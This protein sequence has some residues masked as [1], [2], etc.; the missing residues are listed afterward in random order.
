MPTIFNLGQISEDVYSKKS[1]FKSSHGIKRV[2]GT[3]EGQK[4]G[5]GAALYRCGNV[6]VICYSGSDDLGDVAQD[7]MLFTHYKVQFKQAVDFANRIVRHHGL[8]PAHTF[9][10]GHSLG[11]ALA[12][13]TAWQ[14]TKGNFPPAATYSFNGPNLTPGVWTAAASWVFFKNVDL[15]RPTSA[16]AGGLVVNIR[17]PDDKVSKLGVHLGHSITLKPQ[18]D[19]RGTIPSHKMGNMNKALGRSSIGGCDAYIY[20]KSL[21][22]ASRSIFDY[23]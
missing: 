16:E 13:F 1:Q 11:G 7:L 6:A 21:G 3:L 22:K 9:L 4:S 15:N 17:L 14:M 12:K 2:N 5:F 23:L 19:I 18:R 20:A 10:T 8:D